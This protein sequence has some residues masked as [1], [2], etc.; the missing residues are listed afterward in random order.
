VSE[1]TRGHG[2][3]QIAEILDLR[4]RTGSI[5]FLATSVINK[6]LKRIECGIPDLR[7]TCASIMSRLHGSQVNL[8]SSL[9]RF[10]VSGIRASSLRDR[11]QNQSNSINSHVQSLTRILSTNLKK[12]F[13]FIPKC[14]SLE[15][16]GIDTT[17]K[18]S[19]DAAI[20]MYYGNIFNL[21]HACLYEEKRERRFFNTP[22][23]LNFLALGGWKAGIFEVERDDKIDP[24]TTECGFISAIRFDKREIN[25]ARK[26]PDC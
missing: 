11:S 1:Q 21:F 5:P 22:L 26:C 23:L 4:T 16:A 8:F 14:G 17:S 12:D 18:V 24:I 20:C 15:G 13:E 10:M 6:N 3:D 7:S 9:E 19:S 25:S 2:R